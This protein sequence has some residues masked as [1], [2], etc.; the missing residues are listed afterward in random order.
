MR[1][2]HRSRARRRNIPSRQ[3]RNNSY[4]RD[5]LVVDLHRQRCGRRYEDVHPRTELHHPETIAG[6]HRRTFADPA[7]DAAR[8]DADDL[9]NDNGLTVMIDRDLGV[10]V[11][12]ASFRAL[13]RQEAAGMILHLGHPPTDRHA[14]HVHV[15]RR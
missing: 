15:H 1:V 9:P 2:Q 14:I 6:V 10:L 13:A 3:P 11:Q 7:H 8:E 4:A 12:V 5:R